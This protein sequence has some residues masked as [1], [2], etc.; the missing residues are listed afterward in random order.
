MKFWSVTKGKVTNDDVESGT[1]VA[2][3][4]GALK[5]KAG[6]GYIYLH[7]I[8]LEGKSK[9]SVKDFMNGAGKNYIGMKFEKSM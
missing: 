2:F 5:V 7:E 9:M 3:D 4:N 1:I 6:E 8:Q